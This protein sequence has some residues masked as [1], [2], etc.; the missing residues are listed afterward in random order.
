MTLSSAITLTINYVLLFISVYNKNGMLYL[1]PVVHSY[2]FYLSNLFIAHWI[3][4]IMWLEEILAL[5]RNIGIIWFCSIFIE[6]GI[7]LF[8]WHTFNHIWMKE[9]AFL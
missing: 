2:L 8:D 7:V 5:V 9:N 4:P 6:F 3:Y 1:L